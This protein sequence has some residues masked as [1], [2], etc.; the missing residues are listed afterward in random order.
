M[1]IN[2]EY[3][4]IYRKENGDYYI[5]NSIETD[6]DIEIELDDRLE[7]EGSIVSEK[8]IISNN[9]II[10]RDDINAGC[11]I[12]AGGSICVGE[13]IDCGLRIFAGASIYDSEEEAQKTISCAELRNGQI[14]YGELVI[15]GYVD[16]DRKKEGR[17]ENE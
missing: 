8:S 3:S 2:K 9:T 17:K 14:A 11:G 16:K 4:W 5:P 1:K 6:E 12:E 10:A 7:V 15:T 13:Y